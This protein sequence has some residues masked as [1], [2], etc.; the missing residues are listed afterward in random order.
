M[1]DSHDDVARLGELL[2]DIDFCM[3]T[4]IDAGGQLHARPM[5]T[6]RSEFDGTL[7]FLTDRDSHKVED[8][9]RNPQVIA[10]YAK[11]DDHTWV[12][13]HGTARLARDEQ[14][15]KELWSPVHRAWWPEG[16]H[17]PNIMVL[18]VDIDRADYWTSNG[19]K[20]TQLIGFA[21]AVLGAGSGE[22]LGEQGT[23]RP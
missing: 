1:P 17:D 13:V 9:E 7:R 21:K 12:C 11:P 18:S 3:L 22:D 20:V 19:G 23:I 2:E 14:L 8:I 10:T 5:S 6:Q 15:I 4:T 16:R